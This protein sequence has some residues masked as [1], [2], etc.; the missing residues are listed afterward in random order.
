MTIGHKLQCSVDVPR[1]AVGGMVHSC[2]LLSATPSITV[3]SQTFLS[4]HD[5]RHVQH[6]TCCSVWQPVLTLKD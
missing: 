3:N 2:I 1:D 6:Q 5:Q 4:A